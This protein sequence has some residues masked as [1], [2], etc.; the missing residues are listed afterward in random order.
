MLSVNFSLINKK[1]Q[2]QKIPHQMVKDF[3]FL[4][5]Q[6]V[7][8]SNRFYLQLEEFSYNLKQLTIV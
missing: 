8:K 1:T 6:T 7:T 2:K 5:G 4:V 3:I